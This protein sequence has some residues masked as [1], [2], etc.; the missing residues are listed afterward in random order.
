LI[1]P[2]ESKMSRDIHCR[3]RV[4]MTIH[5]NLKNKIISSLDQRTN[6]TWSEEIHLIM[7]SCLKALI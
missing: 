2:I 3:T 4:H 6:V 5:N 7:T 1:P